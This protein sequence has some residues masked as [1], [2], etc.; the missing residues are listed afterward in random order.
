M[1]AY[2]SRKKMKIFFPSHCLRHNS[3]FILGWKK[4][5]ENIFVAVTVICSSV[6]SNNFWERFSGIL[7]ENK[8]EFNSVSL[9][10]FGIWINEND[11]RSVGDFFDSAKAFVMSLTKEMI[12]V[13]LARNAHVPQVYVFSD[14]F[15]A[16][17]CVIVLYRQPSGNSFL[18]AG[19]ASGNNSDFWRQLQCHKQVPS[20]ELSEVFVLLNRSHHD[21]VGIL[22]MVE[23]KDNLP[24]SN[25]AG[26]FISLVLKALRR[27]CGLFSQR[28][29]I[30]LSICSKI[31]KF[32]SS[33]SAVILQCCVRFSQVKVLCTCVAQLTS[34]KNKHDSNLS[35]SRSS[36]GTTNVSKEKND[37][38]PS[39]WFGSLVTAISID[40]I[41]G[42]VIVIWL[43]SNGYGMCA[44]D[45]VMEKTDAVVEFLRALLD[46]IK[47]APA[48]LKL[49][50][51]LAEYLST[52]FLYHIYLWQIYLSCVEPYLQIITSAVIMSG[53]FGVT[54]LLS[55]LSE[56]LSII[57]LHIYCFYVYA[58]RLYNF[59]LKKLITLFRLFTG[60][61]K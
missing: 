25:N 36:S 51:Q 32:L 27:A 33:L 47:G 46:W 55:L 13:R 11:E 24:S 54:F 43:F 48:G 19:P 49:N 59:Q 37:V 42:I 20:T 22:A 16:D 39:V 1:A 26:V 10:V 15:T 7:S 56:V 9:S 14:K 17:G 57:T 53:C 23:A 18:T 41:L 50:K 4:E 28:S 52:F 60:T 21:E 31:V 38:F 35:E 61:R 45:F 58:A 40:I 8:L 2:M 44:T 5:Q 6:I 30:N 29:M 34:P 12:I 3:G